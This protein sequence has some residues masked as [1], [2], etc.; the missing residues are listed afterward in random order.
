M[1]QPHEKLP[2]PRTPKPL[3]E[4]IRVLD[5]ELPKLRVSGESACR[6]VF[7]TVGHERALL[8]LRLAW[9]ALAE[10]FQL[11]RGSRNEPLGHLALARI[12]ETAVHA[13]VAGYSQAVVDA[14]HEPKPAGASLENQFY[15]EY[16]DLPEDERPDSVDDYIRQRKA[17][18]GGPVKPED[19]HQA[20]EA[21][22]QER[23]RAEV[24]SLAD[25]D[26]D[27]LRVT[28]SWMTDEA[29]ESRERYAETVRTL[30]AF[31]LTTVHGVG[32]DNPH[33]PAV[34]VTV[35]M[36]SAFALELGERVWSDPGSRLGEAIVKAHAA[37]RAD[38]AAKMHE[39][40]ITLWG[41][42]QPDE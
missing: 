36:D 9:E 6:R 14:M 38:F 18:Q 11:A 40:G 21:A 27:K 32:K 29:A 37:A 30:Q 23:I 22:A 13:A 41:D 39:N 31:D 3:E 33:N 25:L 12:I 35:S 1:T 24:G 7:V 28:E 5:E 10:E 16:W 34:K 20:D 17:E 26:P 4:R 42:G 19:Q 8:E 2:P 15:D